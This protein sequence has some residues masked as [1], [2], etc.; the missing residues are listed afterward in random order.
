MKLFI[1]GL[2]ILLILVCQIYKII[3]E[4]SPN[5]KIN[6]TEN[7]QKIEREQMSREDYEENI[8]HHNDFIDGTMDYYNKLIDKKKFELDTKLGSDFGKDFVYLDSKNRLLFHNRAKYLREKHKEGFHGDNV[9]KNVAKDIDKCREIKK[10]GMLDEIGYE[11]C[12]YCGKLGDKKGYQGANKKGYNQ[13]GKFDYMPNAIGGKE[14]GPDVCPND[15]LEAHPPKASD[16]KKELGNRWAT[17]AY[18]CEKI[19]LQDKCS[20]VKNCGELSDMDGLGRICGWCPSN[21]AYPRDDDYGILYSNDNIINSAAPHSDKTDG[22][23]KTIKGDRCGALNETYTDE[24]GKLTRYFS[25][26]QK[27]SECSVCDNSGGQISRVNG[28]QTYPAWSDECIQ[29][30]WAGDT[31]SVK[32]IGK[33]SS[34]ILVKCTTNYDE[35]PSAESGGIHNKNYGDKNIGSRTNNGWG[36]KKWYKVRNDMRQ[37]VTYPLFNFKKDYNTKISEK[38]PKLMWTFGDGYDGKGVPTELDEYGNLLLDN[39][40]RH[41]Y[42]MNSEIDD[43]ASKYRKTE[44]TYPDLRIDEKW[45]QCFNKENKDN[46]LKCVP[47]RALRAAENIVVKRPGKDK[48]DY[49]DLAKWTGRCNYLKNENKCEVAE[50]YPNGSKSDTT[51]MCKEIS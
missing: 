16:K 8:Q 49:K 46:E 9:R 28:T 45:K 27:A 14:I 22:I 43:Q 31:G 25:S 36:N 26:L 37:Q 20:E 40:V 44:H 34:K 19:Q 4:K 38:N 10:C 13:D 50:K 7:L 11:N 24:N 32:G 18:D 42:I 39:D 12:G 48:Y 35:L 6:I 47:I 5:Q 21:K 23:D 1:L 17:T 15:A 2:I 41:S 51:I 3:Q 30:L 29:D 33:L